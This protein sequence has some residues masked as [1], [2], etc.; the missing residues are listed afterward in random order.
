MIL[1]SPA[2]GGPAGSAFAI[3]LAEHQRLAAQL[4]AHFGNANF[5]PLAPNAAMQFAIAHHDSGWHDL[6]LAPPGDPATRLPCALGRHPVAQSLSVAARSIALNEAHHPYCGLLVSMHQAGLYNGR[7]GL[8]SALPARTLAPA[9]RALVNPFLQAEAARQTRLRG[10]LHADPARRPAAD[11]GVVFANYL[12]LQFFDRLALALNLG[13][14][15]GVRRLVIDRVPAGGGFERDVTVTPVEG[16]VVLA[17][18]PFDGEFEV[19]YEGRVVMPDAGV[20]DWGG[21]LREVAVEE[22]RFWV[23]RESR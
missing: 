17:P 6:D 4:A 7:Y 20:A 1:Q 13:G 15:G 14:P 18:Y 23:R 16:G 8:Q 3:T 5:A 11:D 10:L 12:L 19:E 21:S 9:E 2:P 22:Q